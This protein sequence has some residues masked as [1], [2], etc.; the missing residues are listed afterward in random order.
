MGVAEKP[1]VNLHFVVWL[2]IVVTGRLNMWG[3]VRRHGWGLAACLLANASRSTFPGAIKAALALSAQKREN[4][5]G[6]E[7]QRELGGGGGR[8]G[9]RLVGRNGVHSTQPSLP[10]R[11]PS[12]RTPRSTTQS[13]KKDRNWVFC[14]PFC[15]PEDQQ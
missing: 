2:V 5:Q 1:S 15:F 13:R 7:A 4:H 11:P 9:M 14:F 6:Q 8:A 3:T 10:L 12:P